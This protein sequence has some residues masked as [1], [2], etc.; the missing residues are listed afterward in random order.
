M[1]T[2]TQFGHLQ[3]LA[4]PVVHAGTDRRRR[5]QTSPLD[6]LDLSADGGNRPIGGDQAE[7]E[8]VAFCGHITVQIV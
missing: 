7:A 4:W 1:Q 3:A 2:M 5:A 6:R 8:K